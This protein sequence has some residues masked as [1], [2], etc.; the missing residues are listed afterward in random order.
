LLT[1]QLSSASPRAQKNDMLPLRTRLNLG[2]RYVKL[3][4]K[5]VTARAVIVARET[6]RSYADY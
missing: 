3:Y 2:G 5:I 6:A 4:R 1:D